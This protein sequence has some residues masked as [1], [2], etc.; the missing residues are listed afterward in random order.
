MLQLVYH[1]PPSVSRTALHLLEAFR[2]AD[3]LPELEAI[4]ADESRNM[5]Q[6]IDALRAITALPGDLFR[7]QFAMYT[8]L[9]LENRSRYDHRGAALLYDLRTFADK[10]P[11]NRDWFFEA[12][13]LSES[14]AIVHFL[15]ETLSYAMSEDMHNR[16]AQKLVDLLDRYPHLLN[17]SIANALLQSRVTATITE[18]LERH[19]EL[20]IEIYLK[21]VAERDFLFLD[22][23]WEKLHLILMKRDKDYA[24]RYEVYQ[25]RWEA[26]RQHREHTT[27]VWRTSPAYMLLSELYENA[28]AGDKSAYDKL[29]KI[30]R[31]WQRNVPLA[32][33]AT[34]FVGK[35]LPQYDAVDTLC[36]LLKRPGNRWQYNE[37]VRYEAGEALR[38]TIS[39]KI[40]EIMVDTCFISADNE[41][42][43]RLLD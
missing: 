3:I 15:S 6:R 30:A 37:P 9:S 42:I 40:W 14:D 12:F 10:H 38:E 26:A 29:V 28:I 7:P 17:T 1:A 22:D 20:V 35:L 13:E 43:T 8:K 11:S 25:A 36:F 33:A 24:Q 34:Y 32:A 18:W 27:S 21:N 4:L 41:L 16:L 5:W 23:R 39:P 31:K 19:L 2:S